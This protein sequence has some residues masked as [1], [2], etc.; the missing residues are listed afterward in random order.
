MSAPSIIRGSSVKKGGIV[1]VDRGEGITELRESK[2][3]IMVLVVSLNEEVKFFRGRINT[4]LIQTI[5]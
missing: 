5:L 3:E 1:V 2:S 4:N